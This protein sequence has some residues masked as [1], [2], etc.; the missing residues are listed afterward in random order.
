[1]RI[2]EVCKKTGLTDKAIR[3]YIANRLINPAFTENY[4]GRKNYN[5]SDDD[6]DVLNKIALLRRYDFSVNDIRK[7][8]NNNDNVLSILEKHLNNTKQNVEESSMVLANLTN[9]YDKSV[10][11]VDELCIILNEN[12]EPNNFEIMNF[13]NSVWEKIKRKMPALLVICIVGF[14]VSILLLIAVT[15]LLSKLFL[16]LD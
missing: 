7:M 2:K 8:L 15:I 4:S 14:T 9:A 11:D 16:L 10:S 12:L 13:I 5:F 1:M 6:V 3:L